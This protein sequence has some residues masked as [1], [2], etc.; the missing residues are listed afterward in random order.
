[1][2]TD[3]QPD[4]VCIVTP[5]T[6]MKRTVLTICEVG[7]SVRG[8]QCEKPI[9]GVLKDADAMVSACEAASIM[10]GGGNAQRCIPAL[11]E[12]AL[13]LR[14]E[15]YGTIVGASVHGFQGEIVGGGV[16]AISVL[17]LLLNEEVGAVINFVHKKKLWCT[18]LMKFYLK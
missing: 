9:G 17:R 13:R 10:L 18:K 5:V 1:M 15:V 8:I 6:Y 7:S 12:L 16:Q 4:I 11:Q 3:Q 2:L 14:D